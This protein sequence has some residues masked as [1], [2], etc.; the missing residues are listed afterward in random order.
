MARGTASILNSSTASHR[1]DAHYGPE[2]TAVT[3][4]STPAALSHTASSAVR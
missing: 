2:V 1:C 4:G 3:T